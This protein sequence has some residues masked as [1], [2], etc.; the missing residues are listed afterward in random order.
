MIKISYVL[1]WGF[2]WVLFLAWV[3][4]GLDKVIVPILEKIE[5]SI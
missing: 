2:F 5:R 4:A 3:Q 1:K